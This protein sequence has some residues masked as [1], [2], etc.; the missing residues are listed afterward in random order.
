MSPIVRVE[1]IANLQSNEAAFITIARFFSNHMAGLGWFHWFDGGMPIENSYQPG[2]PAAAA[3]VSWVSGWPIARAFHVV[4]ASAYCLGPV[5]L[6]WMVFDRTEQLY[7]AALAGL[8][9]SVFSSGPLLVS[10]LR[11]HDDFWMPL[12][13]YNLVYY[14]DAPHVAGLALVPLAIAFVRRAILRRDPTSVA[15]AVAFCALSR[16]AP[17]T[18]SALRKQ[19]SAPVER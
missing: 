14:G 12:R 13:L 10:T 6:F 11:V 8:L 19:S 16:V 18:H 9:W 15:G 2:L 17:R 7:T 5:A 3:L 4:I 1:F